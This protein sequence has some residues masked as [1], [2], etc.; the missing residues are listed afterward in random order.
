MNFRFLNFIFL[1]LICSHAVMAIDPVYDGD[2]GIRANVF[3][4]N[5]LACHSSELTGSQRNGAPSNVNWDTYSVALAKADRAVVRAVDRMSMPPSFSGLP[6]LTQEQK[7]AM[8]AWQQAGFPETE[9]VNIQSNATFDVT[10]L[11]LTLPVLHVGELTY[12]ATFKLIE[13]PNSE[14]G[15]GFNLESAELTDNT[16]ATAATFI[17]ETAIVEM[18]EVDILNAGDGANKI[19]VQMQ[20]IPNATLIQFAVTSIGFIN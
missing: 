16:S 13:L 10:D 12:Q 15:F 3:A 2:N 14:L 9:V 6:T 8:L 20:L 4:S 5:C 17:F 7:D 1:Y 11:I 19:N 18:P